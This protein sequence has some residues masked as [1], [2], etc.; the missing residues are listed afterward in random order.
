MNIRRIPPYL[1]V[2]ALLS[3]SAPFARAEIKSGNDRF[4]GRGTS[5]PY[6]ISFQ[7]VDPRSVTVR[8]NGMRLMP[9][10]DYLF[11]PGMGMLSFSDSVKTTDIVDISYDYDSDVARKPGASSGSF[12]LLGGNTGGLSLNY[13]FKPDG[14]GNQSL[15]GM[16]FNGQAML[17][18]ATL[19]TNFML[20]KSAGTAPGREAQNMQFNLKQDKGALTYS[21]G[22]SHVG[23]NFSQADALKLLKG[24]DAMDLAGKFQFTNGGALNFKRVTNV[25]PD[26]KK[27]TLTSSLLSGGLDMNLSSSSHF[28]ALHQRQDSSQG[29]TTLAQAIDR[30][31]LDQKIGGKTAATLIQ[32]TVTN[33]KNG[34]SET[35]KATRLN[36]TM[37]GDHGLKLSTNLAM[38]DSD[39]SGA[40]RDMSLSLAR[41]DGPLKMTMDLTDRKADA[42]DASSHKLGLESLRGGLKWTASLVGSKTTAAHNEV[43]SFGLAHQAKEGLQ[44]S[45]GFA[46]YAGTEKSGTGT[47]FGLSG[48]GFLGLT[49]AA[50][51][52]DDFLSQGNKTNT[53]VTMKMDGIKNVKVDG[54]YLENDMGNVPVEA[55]HLNIQAAPSD[56]VKVTATH[57]RDLNDKVDTEVNKLEMGIVPAKAMTLTASLVDQTNAGV[58][59]QTQGVALS[60][61]PSDKMKL[62]AAFQDG[63]GTAGQTASRSATLALTPVKDKFSFSGS[64]QEETKAEVDT[65]VAVLQ[66]DIKPNDVVSMSSYYKSRDTSSATDP[67]NTLN[68]AL[69]LKPNSSF[70]IAGTYSANPE[71][72]NEVLRLVRRGLSLQTNVGGLTFTGGYLSE[73]SLIDDSGGARAQF[74]LGLRISK[75]SQLQGGFEQT[76]GAVRGYTPVLSYNMKYTQDMGSDFNLLLEGDVTQRD[77]SVPQDQRQ[78]VKATA[79]LGIR[80]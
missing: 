54:A 50:T 27:G 62:T 57:A 61:A 5:G 19:T 6:S 40:A 29:G 75:T 60:A 9:T 58:S 77:N 31:Q 7:N 1:I 15:S 28:T 47:Q 59:A 55:K 76:I 39:K 45:A 35:V 66:A 73:E 53:N 30:L 26:A 10:Q 79:N 18:S 44:W 52:L 11:D 71:E 63:D 12:A 69:T 13:S 8:K 51:R 21:L 74:K 33:A 80:F 37:T 23:A 38:T 17:G 67:I 43:A 68:A 72:K 36:A 78:E 70:Q 65:Q 22:Y 3:A 4:F 41:G 34:D 49:F 16:G 24:S 25:T 56:V 64:I 32:E 2:S 46:N 14:Q 20:D 42:G 48:K